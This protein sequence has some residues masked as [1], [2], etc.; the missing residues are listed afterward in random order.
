M[1]KGLAV[2]L[3]VLLVGLVGC[4]DVNANRYGSMAL[5]ND[6]L[7]Y[8]AND[9]V[10]KYASET[11]VKVEEAESPYFDIFEQDGTVQISYRDSGDVSV[12]TPY[13]ERLDGAGQIL[14]NDEFVYARYPGGDGQIVVYQIV[15]AEDETE[16]LEFV[17]E[18]EF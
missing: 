16:K 5:H 10:Y 8:Y 15:K 2:I 18:I 9:F 1:R 3:C 13:T 4:K 14:Y 12:E 7:Y 6:E 17:A 11:S